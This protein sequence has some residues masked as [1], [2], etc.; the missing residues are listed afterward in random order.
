MELHAS[1]NVTVT[2][3]EAESATEIGTTAAELVMQFSKTDYATS[4]EV[5]DDMDKLLTMF[6]G[7][8]MEM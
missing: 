1:F 3:R 4:G 5:F 6:V 2:N 7:R 8:S